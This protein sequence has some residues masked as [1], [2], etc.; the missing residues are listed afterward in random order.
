MTGSVATL[1]ARLSV[2][3]ILPPDVS[4]AIEFVVDTGFAGSLSLPPEAVAAMGL[5]Y[6]GT[7]EAKLADG[8]HRDVDAYIAVIEWSGKR[9]V[10]DVLSMGHRPLLGTQLLANTE[11]LCHFREGGLVRVNPLQPERV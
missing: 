2:K 6:R 10:V 8:S 4:L 9:L 11:L 3:F 5:P 7:F 1:Q